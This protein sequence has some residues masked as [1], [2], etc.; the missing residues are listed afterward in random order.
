MVILSERELINLA[1][2]QSY[3]LVHGRHGAEIGQVKGLDQVQQGDLGGEVDRDLGLVG[4]GDL[5]AKLQVGVITCRP[6]VTR[7]GDWLSEL[8]SLVL[9][10]VLMKFSSHRHVLMALETVRLG[11]VKSVWSSGK[12][13]EMS[14]SRSSTIRHVSATSSDRGTWMASIR[15]I[16]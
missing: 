2:K 6:P 3:L 4:K 16:T 1:E 13:E 10:K 5:R 9:P 14:I 8:Y 11:S 7:L 15:N 12:T